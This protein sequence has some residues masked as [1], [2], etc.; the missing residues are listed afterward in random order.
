MAA[1]HHLTAGYL[2]GAQ[3][4]PLVLWTTGV[5]FVS[6]EEMAS[7]LLFTVPLL[8][9]GTFVLALVVQPDNPEIKL[10]RQHFTTLL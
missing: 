3:K 4:M 9:E 1:F 8:F 7:I 10:G 2:D 5:R 6:C